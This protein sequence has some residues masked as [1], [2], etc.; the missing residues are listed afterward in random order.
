MDFKA[1][2]IEDVWNWGVVGSETCGFSGAQKQLVSSTQQVP[3]FMFRT[4]ISACLSYRDSSEY[5]IGSMQR[6]AYFVGSRR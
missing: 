4:D 3:A 1:C 2:G 6:V 5:R